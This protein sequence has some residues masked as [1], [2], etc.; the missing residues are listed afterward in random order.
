MCLVFSESLS[1]LV[2]FAT[3]SIIKRH[4]NH[5]PIPYHATIIH[6]SFVRRL[7][8]HLR[9]TTN[10]ERTHTHA[11]SYTMIRLIWLIQSNSIRNNQSNTVAAN[12][13]TVLLFRNNFLG[14]WSSAFSAFGH[15]T[16]RTHEEKTK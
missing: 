11:H 13:K 2:V 12:T 6:S 7:R 3:A 8:P 1:S 15:R 14:P 9:F 4:W 16:K 5:Q 10:E